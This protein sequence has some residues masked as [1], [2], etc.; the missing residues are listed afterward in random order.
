MCKA[1]HFFTA[2]LLAVLMLPLSA[3]GEIGFQITDYKPDRF[4]DKQL[5]VTGGVSY[6]DYDQKY[7]N[8]IMPFDSYSLYGN[9]YNPINSSG[10]LGFNY[11]STYQDLQRY[12]YLSLSANASYN[13][14]KSV[15]SSVTDYPEN[16]LGNSRSEY[17][18]EWYTLSA[19]PN[20]GWRKYLKDDI[21]FT[22]SAGGSYS[23]TDYSIYQYGNEYNDL[24]YPNAS[25][26]YNTSYSN[27]RSRQPY[28]SSSYVIYLTAG[29]GW[30]RTYSGMYAATA[31]YIVEEL[32]KNNLLK[33]EPSREQMLRL[34]ELV[35]KNKLLHAVDKRIRTIESLQEILDYLAAE[36]LIQ[37]DQ[38]MTYL[39]TSDV[40]SY[41][42]MTGR[43]FGFLFRIAGG[44]EL[45]GYESD[46]DYGSTYL[47]VQQR[48][49]VDTADV[50][51]TTY[52]YVSSNMSRANRKR[53]GT[54]PYLLIAASYSKPLNFKWQLYT[55]FNLQ[56][57]LSSTV[58]QEAES[59]Y[60]EP[61]D[62]TRFGETEFE[63]KNFYMATLYSTLYYIPNSR[64]L[65]SM[66][67]SLGYGGFDRT[68]TETE[69][70]GGVETDKVVRKVSYDEMILTLRLSATYRI[71]IPTNVNLSVEYNN[72]Y[73]PRNVYISYND[74]EYETLYLSASVMHY[75]F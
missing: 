66:Y 35:Y 68:D 15:S 1:R 19:Y 67:G 32:R 27:S 26:Y 11:S 69:K 61:A 36:G 40:W 14:Q 52:Y 49:H 30:G 4:V 6:Q 57:Y 24:Y 43:D 37:N 42:P 10:S 54:L 22:I 29:P 60:L 55:S 17:Y 72:G 33:A 45:E 34:C 41:F 70:M 7:E 3:A 44:L 12:F 75:L 23:L 50:I 56:Y 20:L 51:D 64:T 74:F 53:T 21:S 9:K 73:H 8:T 31:I 63:F 2:M 13:R 25:G 48:Y 28:N 59:K 38:S 62:T 65:L 16:Y 39:L 47:S 58:N 18:Y 71:T 46:N 5:Y